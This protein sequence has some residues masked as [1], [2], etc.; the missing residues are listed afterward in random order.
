MRMKRAFI[1]KFSSE[2]QEAAWWDSHR[3]EIEADIQQGL[4]TSIE[5]TKVSLASSKPTRDNEVQSH[6]QTKGPRWA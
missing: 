1:P 5:V 4:V 6:R 3:S 2:A